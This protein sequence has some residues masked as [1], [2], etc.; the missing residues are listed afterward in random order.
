MLRTQPFNISKWLYREILSRHLLL[1]LYINK[2]MFA[3]DYVIY[4]FSRGLSPC[5]YLAHGFPLV[6]SDL[7]SPF[8]HI[9]SHFF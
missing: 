4:W 5:L 2:F 9:V 1:L 3:F 8:S 6:H 7:A